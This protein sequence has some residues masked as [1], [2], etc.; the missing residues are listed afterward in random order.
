MNLCRLSKDQASKLLQKL[1]D[2]G[3]LINH[4]TRR[5]AFYTLPDV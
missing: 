1:R 3:L 2:K 4:G 5:A